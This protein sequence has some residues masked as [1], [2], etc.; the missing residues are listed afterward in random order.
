MLIVVLVVIPASKY[1]SAE[2]LLTAR[3]FDNAIAAFTDLGDYKDASERITECYYQ[4]AASLLENGQYDEAAIAFG[5]AGDYS[6]A[7]QRSFD[8]WNDITRDIISGGYT[9]Q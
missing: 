3:E 9:I 4:Q 2:A 8:L 6:D 1:K 5:K 7:S